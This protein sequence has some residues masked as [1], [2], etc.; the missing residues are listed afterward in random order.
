[1]TEEEKGAS[2]FGRSIDLVEGDPLEEIF[3][4]NL[5]DFIS[6]NL[7]S[8]ELAEKIG[9]SDKNKTI[10]LKN[11]LSELISVYSMDNTLSVI[12]FN[13]KDDYIIYNSIA[14]TMTQIVENDA[15]YVYL[16]REFAC[17]L[18]NVSRDIV[19]AGASEDFEKDIFSENIGFNL[20]EDTEPVVQAVKKIQTVEVSP[21]NIGHIKKFTRLKEDNV[22]E[23]IAVPMHNNANVVGVFVLENF[24][25]KKIKSDFLNLIES[26]AKLFGTSISLQK[27]INLAN[28]LID[29][30]DSEIVDLQHM[31][32]ELTALIGDLGD[33]QE[34]FI[35][36]LAHA[37]D[38]KGQYNVAHSENTAKLSREL[39][40]ELG[41][42]EKTKDL[43]FYAGLL[44]NIGKIALPEE[45]FS[46]R[47]KLSKEDWDKLKTYS[48]IGVNI[49]MKINFLSEVV[50][51]ICYHK[52]RY[53]GS[54][55]PEGLARMSIPLGSRII[56]VA[57]AYSA[58]T[59]DRAFRKAMTKEQ[60]LTIMKQEAGIKWDPI[61]V[62]ALYDVVN[63]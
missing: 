10:K 45:L 26:M 33:N 61:I 2:L 49:L 3:A 19:L 23:Y 25:G 11:Q 22:T 7:I 5:G 35:K 55:E 29:S 32:A 24:N 40:T 1:M 12:G 56:A 38:I 36:A 28:D 4:L 8:K 50:P 60:A 41:L 48:N 34:T 47:G 18:D 58:M 62:D 31:R 16:T 52:E 53:D 54:G 20:D 15:C 59:S 6:E 13:S 57:D 14:K 42:N 63:K 9:K 44:S 39:A 21:E 27:T 30:T 51:Y 17:G 37:V 46:N 43:I